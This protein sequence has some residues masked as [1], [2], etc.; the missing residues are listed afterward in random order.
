MKLW[1]LEEEKLSK[2]KAG[3]IEIMKEELDTM[4][5]KL[6]EARRGQN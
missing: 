4:R 3:T 5:E 6:A 1:V 2:V